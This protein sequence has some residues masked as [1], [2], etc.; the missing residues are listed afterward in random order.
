MSQFVQDVPWQAEVSIFKLSI[1]IQGAP[2]IPSP[3]PPHPKKEIIFLISFYFLSFLAKMKM[4]HLHHQ[5]YWFYISV[6]FK[7]FCTLNMIFWVKTVL[8][9][10]PVN[11]TLLTLQLVYDYFAKTLVENK[12]YDKR[13]LQPLK[14]HKDFW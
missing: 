6:L 9:V 5:D 13:I 3:P 12:G 2:Q 4:L 1:N 11:P 7:V 10:S 14:T 8:I